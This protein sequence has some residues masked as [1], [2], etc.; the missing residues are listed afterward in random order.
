MLTR[1]CDVRCWLAPYLAKSEEMFPDFRNCLLRCITSELTRV[2]L[3]RRTE[4]HA[5]LHRR[6]SSRGLTYWL[7]AA[8]EEREQQLSCRRSCDCI[9]P[10]NGEVM[11]HL[12][13][14]FVS[15]TFLVTEGSETWSVHVPRKLYVE[16]HIRNGDEDP[17]ILPVRIM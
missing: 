2:T 8:S 10:S 12:Q 7:T 15:I 6:E 11:F 9:R 1:F 3:T 5:C 16:M 13:I 4:R 17:V 14:Y